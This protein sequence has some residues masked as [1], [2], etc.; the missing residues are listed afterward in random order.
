MR[1][2]N[3]HVR[4]D[5]IVGIELLHLRD[6]VHVLQRDA[7]GHLLCRLDRTLHYASCLFNEPRCLRRTQLQLHRSI[8]LQDYE[9]EEN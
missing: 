4:V 9:N 1:Q 5:G 7:T 3:A 2:T 6:F 8:R